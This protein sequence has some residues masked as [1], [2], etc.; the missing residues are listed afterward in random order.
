[1][2]PWKYYLHASAWI[3][4]LNS[5]GTFLSNL[6]PQ[7]DTNQTGVDK[8]GVSFCQ[9]PHGEGVNGVSFY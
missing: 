3:K 9:F 4:I 7:Y 5:L 2:L 1:M 8:N 6:S